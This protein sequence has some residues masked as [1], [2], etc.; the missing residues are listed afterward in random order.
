MNAEKGVSGVTP[1]R[2][3]YWDCVKGLAILLIVLGHVTGALYHEKM[4]TA[5]WVRQMTDQMLLGGLAAFYFV[6]GHFLLRSTRKDFRPF[7]SSK[8][9]TLVVPYFVW[10]ILQGAAESMASGWVTVDRS[11]GR[12]LLTMWYEPYWQFWFLYVLFLASVLTWV[13]LRFLN[14]AGVMCFAIMLHIAHRW[15]GPIGWSMADRLYSDYF[16]V[17][18]GVWLG[19]AVPGIFERLSKSSVSRILFLPTLLV[20]LSVG[21]WGIVSI[22]TPWFAW[23]PLL[24]GFA[25]LVGAWQV[26]QGL[27]GST[28]AFLGRRSMSIYLMHVLGIGSAKVIGYRLLGSQFFGAHFLFRVTVGIGMPLILVW[29]ADRYWFSSS[30]AV[31]PAES[32]WQ[33]LQALNRN[34]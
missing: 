6:S 2:I 29:I 32:L 31:K 34:E 27:A 17:A 21:A 1:N 22:K 33:E 16:M 23:L 4:L 20:P 5:D 11:F 25:T 7:I 19:S 15:I 24:V 10:T 28:I 3:R 9:R 13:L 8:V 14:P 30:L 18:S 26:D 12:L